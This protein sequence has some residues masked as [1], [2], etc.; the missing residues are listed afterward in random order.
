MSVIKIKWLETITPSAQ[1]KKKKP[2]KTAW[3][4]EWYFFVEPGITAPKLNRD[5]ILCLKRLIF[6]Q[7]Y[8]ICEKNKTPKC[9]N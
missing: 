8:E 7:A 5:L 3:K 4:I 6:N 1:K 2:A 9:Y